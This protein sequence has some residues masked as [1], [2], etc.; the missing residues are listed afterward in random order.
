[1]KVASCR[2]LLVAAILTVMTRVALAHPHMFF[3]S[4][5]QF[6]LDDEGKLSGLRTV[7][8]V[9]ELNTLYTFT[10]LGVNADG[11]QILNADEQEKIAATVV[12]GFGH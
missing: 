6:L 8:L 3:S 4:T 1:M 10:E 5:A 2:F 9:D 7:F 11:D 12:E